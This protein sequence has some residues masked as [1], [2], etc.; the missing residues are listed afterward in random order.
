MTGYKKEK[1]IMETPNYI[2]RNNTSWFKRL[3]VYIASFAL[4]Y[5]SIAPSVAA[6]L[7]D[8][9]I[10][11]QLN[12]YAAFE[13]ANSS[14]YQ[15][16]SPSYIE[17]S[18]PNAVN[19]EGFY[20]TLESNYR[21][22][23]GEP[24]YI[25][26]PVGNITT[27]IPIY[28][29]P[30]LV[31]TPLVQSR[32]IRGQ[33]HA[34]LGRNLIDVEN[35][36]YTTEAAQLN[37]LYSNAL[38]YINSVPGIAYGDVLALD[39]ENTG[40]A[41]D[42]VWPEF[43]EING[44]TVVV[45]VVYLANSTI[46]NRRVDSNVTE[47]LSNVSLDA[48]TIDDVN[49]QF[50]RET[51]LDIAN[52]LLNNQ[53]SINSSGELEIVA[54]GS[55]SNL[56]GVIQATG[57]L[58]IGAHSI[59]NQTIVHRYNQYN[60][61]LREQ[62]T[63]YGEIASIN[64]ADG[65]VT[66]RSYED[67][68]FQGAQAFAGGAIT[69]AANGNIYLGSQVVQTSTSGYQAGNYTGSSVSYLQSGLTATDTIQ[70][71]ANGE[72]V[73][74]AAE[75]VSDEGH[76][77][78]LAGLGITV[79]D[80]LQQFRSYREGKF[81]KKEITESTYQTV[82]IRA[83]LDAGKGVRLHSE[84]GDITLTA[85]DISTTQGT[86]VNA[87]NG[88]VNLLMTVEN[89]HYSYSSIKE[90]LFT[91]KTISRGHDIETGVPNSIV[92]GLVVES[93]NGITVEYEGD[94]NLSLD[95]Q[96][97]E[98]AKFEGLEWMAD[99]RANSPNADWH[100][101]D[102]KYEEWK[103]SNT[104]LSPAF[105]AVV[106]IVVAV[107]T[108]GAGTAAAGA[109]L[110][111]A[112][113]TTAGALTVAGAAIAAGTTALITQAVM[114]GINTRLNGGD[115]GDA[116]DQLATSDTVK[117][118]AIAMVTAGAIS[119]VDASFFNVTGDGASA[120]S[121][122][123]TDVLDSA[124]NVTGDFTLSL[125]GQAT[126]AVTHATVQA[127][128]QNVI[129]GA[130]FEDSFVQ[131]LGQQGINHLGQYMANEIKGA[132]G[133][134]DAT[135]LDTAFKYIAHAGAGCVL[136]A[137]SASND[138]STNEHD[139]CTAG[140]G[141]AVIGEL[142]ADIYKSNSQISQ[143]VQ[144]LEEFMDEH[145]I[146]NEI[147]SLTPEQQQELL[148]LDVNATLKELKS[149]Q[150]DGINLA[151]FS[152]ALGAFLSGADAAQINISAN[153]GENAAEY[154]SLSLPFQA[155]TRLLAL[156]GVA[157][158]ATIA[159]TSVNDPELINKISEQLFENGD[160]LD[161]DLLSAIDLSIFSDEDLAAF[162]REGE[163]IILPDGVRF[164]YLIGSDSGVIVEEGRPGLFSTLTTSFLTAEVIAERMLI[165]QMS[166]SNIAASLQLN[167]A[168][169]RSDGKVIALTQEGLDWNTYSGNDFL[170]GFVIIDESQLINQIPGFAA[171]GIDLPD[172]PGYE[173]PDILPT[174][175]GFAGGEQ[176]EIFTDSA[177]SPVHEINLDDTIL[178]FPETNFQPT[179]YFNEN[180]NI[181]S[182]LNELP[183]Q[184][185][186]PAEIRGEVEENLRASVVTSGRFSVATAKV[187]VNGETEYYISVSGPSWRGDRPDEFVD[188]NGR[189][190]EVVREDSGTISP[191]DN[192]NNENHAEQKIY[193]HLTDVYG[194]QAADVTIAVQNNSVRSPGMC[195]GCIATT[196]E[197]AA[198][199]PDFTINVYHGSNMG[200]P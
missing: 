179:S 200:N 16:Q 178:I 86:S 161:S 126:Q 80:D 109:I 15:F 77:E 102:L 73:I 64:S 146:N 97:A 110:G 91:T 198:Q 37:T 67:I 71:I 72:I 34:L 149:F 128:V 140:A 127:G 165:S 22:A 51:F 99:V 26:V 171:G 106:A 84:F 55:V 159:T 153:T 145:G 195:E 46:A 151:R 96:V 197:F 191:A 30:K 42:M 190:Y 50:G 28:T 138:N 35:P 176:P 101:I 186:N 48:L 199:N 105:A 65:S 57:D 66:L 135:A 2:K 115:I 62:G 49:I 177:G 10:Q 60:N 193:S 164:K 147:F 144:K 141:G 11:D 54:G 129:L 188:S 20:Q 136:G 130:D 172:Q 113:T 154:N 69:L 1:T 189:T 78:L 40:L 152:A 53:G 117:S 107:A 118:I 143:D 25:P 121:F 75:L 88:G 12:S 6:V 156:V 59:T 3:T 81:G 27:F 170:A 32:Y 123:V 92:G 14:Q 70:L 155:I 142:V 119:A 85:S 132:F 148:E 36:A 21:H 8:S 194:G 192:Y 137:V 174:L 157:A 4:L 114:T 13:R 184:S 52:D 56:S 167:Q 18:A 9:Y 7:A 41:Y 125:A 76:I 122:L 173:L 134:S 74:D 61:R 58:R 124:G 87:A 116:M 103:E 68:V 94:H 63:R 111:S 108:A 39:Q 185:M 150:R 79:E 100:A 43:R 187:E 44:E 139:G 166:D 104:S 163:L 33:I 23:L 89:D 133:S 181:S 93:A 183:D 112:A 24:T 82:A 162:I 29:T 160:Q 45:P 5:S 90:G 175:G 196:P 83:L 38:N 120:D 19:L 47:L 180:I 131:A 95:E 182:D 17:D 169:V 31:G 168:F 158:T 98:L